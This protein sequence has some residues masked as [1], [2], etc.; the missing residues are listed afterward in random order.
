MGILDT[1]IDAHQKESMQQFE[2]DLIVN[3]ILEPLKDREKTILSKRYGL[4]GHDQQT[5]KTVGEEQGLTRERVRQ[6]EKELLKNLKRGVGELQNFIQ[7]RDLLVNTIAEHGDLMSE[8]ALFAYLGFS[9]PADIN[10][11]R[12]V[13]RLTMEL[14][15]HS[16]D[17]HIRKSW[18]RI[19]FNKEFLHH[20]VK[21]TKE[22]LD[23]HGKPLDPDKFM[24]KIQTSEFYTTHEDKLTPK[25]MLNYL[26][27]AAGL[28]KNPFGEYGLNHWN[29]IKPKDVGD[30]AYLVMKHHGQPEHYSEITNLINQSA[31]DKRKAYKETVHNKLIKDK[32]FVLVGRGIYALAEWGYK[33]GVV[34]DIIVDIIKKSGEPVSRE[35]I[36]AQVLD[37]RM[38]KRNTV[39]VG[40]SNKKLFKKVGK[41]M[42]DLA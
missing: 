5:L 24:K 20:F 31:I 34:A 35:D 6:I 13:L 38:V 7:A 12:F 1:I 18:A 17:E 26:D 33:P 16:A 27:S 3:Q 22:L 30:K 36:I 4:L 32:R 42:Y 25:V 15:E 41:N 21:T 40:L 19:G 23:N 10:A 28:K 11:M 29:E 2:L 39:L 8:Q 9:D 37:T 14:E